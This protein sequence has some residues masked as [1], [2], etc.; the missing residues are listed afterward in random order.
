MKTHFALCLTL[1]SQ[2][3]AYNTYALSGGSSGT[4]GGGSVVISGGV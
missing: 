3:F 2:L 4:R 1:F